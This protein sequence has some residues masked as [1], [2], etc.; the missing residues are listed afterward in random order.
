[1]AI[2]VPL[3]F[4]PAWL[5]NQSIAALMAVVAALLAIATGAM[6]SSRLAQLAAIAAGA[7]AGT[8]L[9]GFLGAE[10]SDES[11]RSLI[12]VFS[13]LVGG[14]AWIAC[15]EPDPPQL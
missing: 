15:V 13:V 14:T 8:W 7:L 2:G 9:A 12:P 3:Q 10:A 11:A 6:V 4:L 5:L 1:L